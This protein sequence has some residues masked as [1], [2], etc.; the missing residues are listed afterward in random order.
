MKKHIIFILALA[1]IASAAQSA[2]PVLPA[3]TRIGVRL[4][5]SLD[6]KR[7]GPGAPFVANVTNAI[8][9]DG[10]V[11]FPQGAE[12]RGHMTESKR[13]G[14]LK[15]RARVQLV[16]DSCEANGKRYHVVTSQVARVSKGHKKRNLTLIGG[17]TGTGAAI[18][19][20][21]GGGVG[22]A[23]GAG[24]GAVA[25]TTGAVITGKRDVRMP[26]ETFLTFTLRRPLTI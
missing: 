7:D 17:G 16:L 23:I 10:R 11:V 4:G 22:A 26:A 14:R 20:I 24:A 3:G 15:G 8:S 21:A 25:G 19:A 5:Q 9:H 13:S 12:C 18:G 1:A 6:T 2:P